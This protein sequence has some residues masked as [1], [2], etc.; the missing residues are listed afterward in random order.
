M[1]YPVPRG[2]NYPKC[3]KTIPGVFVLLGIIIII[4]L[5]FIVFAFFNTVAQPNLPQEA[6]L[7][8]ELGNVGN[9]FISRAS[10]TE[11]IE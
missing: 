7:T 5:P 2:Q 8:L 1:V 3:S 10:F 9:I 11:I 4:W 6:E